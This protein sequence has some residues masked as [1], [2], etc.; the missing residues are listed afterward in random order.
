MLLIKL[1]VER[2]YLRILTISSLVLWLAS[3]HS[4]APISQPS[5]ASGPY[6]HIDWVGGRDDNGFTILE[7]VI[8][9]SDYE[10]HLDGDN[11]L[12]PADSKGRSL[13]LPRTSS[14]GNRDNRHFPGFV[15]VQL[16]KLAQI[17]DVE[18]KVL[19]INEFFFARG[20]NRV[21]VTGFRG[22]GRSIYSDKIKKTNKASHLTADR[23]LSSTATRDMNP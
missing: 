6:D 23:V 17:D 11:R 3:C 7:I 22:M 2:M 8:A 9:R 15:V 14:A 10:F 1:L 20:A 16:H 19:R 4:T 5:T 18:D 21:L 12:L 13:T